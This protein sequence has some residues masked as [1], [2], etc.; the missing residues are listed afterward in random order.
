MK[1]AVLGIWHLG[2]VVSACIASKKNR[3]FAIDRDKL[4]IEKLNSAKAPIFEP[5]LNKLLQKKIDE[6][7]LS[8]HSD[9]DCISGVDVL[10]V[11][12][13]TPVDDDDN[14]DI[15]FVIDNIK[16]AIKFVTDTTLILLSS[17]LPVGST[18]KLEKYVNRN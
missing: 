14:A 8:F 13:D 15:N 1:I 11:T 2:S 9:M 16:E 4:K 7:Q 17:Q 12:Y 6:N 3:V 5:N 18:R 10:W